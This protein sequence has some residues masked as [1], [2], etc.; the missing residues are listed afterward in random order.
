MRSIRPPN[1]EGTQ[2]PGCFTVGCH[3]KRRKDPLPACGPA[4]LRCGMGSRLPEL[5][6][7]EFARSISAVSPEALSAR[8][9]DGLYQHYL[10]LARW[11]ERV[12]LIGPGTVAEAIGRHYGE[13]LAALP[14][15]PPDA[16]VAVDVGSGAGFPGLVLAAARPELQMT[17][18]EPREKKWAF[19][20]AAA[21]RASL[22]CRCLDARVGNP[23]PAGLPERIDLLTVRALKLDAQVLGAIARR[24]APQGS[25]LL[26]LGGEDPDLPLRLRPGRSLALP[27]SERR[28]I[29]ELRPREAS[30]RAES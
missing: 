16:R 21:R 18:V 13:A 14:L 26:W 9:L 1:R 6:R 10:E 27:G 11:N 15:V 22:P 23:L 24:L 28:R 3:V 29:L 12:A 2:R 8:T 5:G 30:E 17:L 7:D 20:Q 25:V 4:A 19:L